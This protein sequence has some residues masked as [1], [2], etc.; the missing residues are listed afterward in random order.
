M[1]SYTVTATLRSRHPGA[2]WADT[3]H[4][5]LGTYGAATAVDAR[6]RAQVIIT[7][8]AASVRQA[9]DLAGA[10]LTEHPVVELHAQLTSDYDNPVRD[11]PPLLSIADAATQL[12]ITRQAVLD[13]I[14]RG[15]L[16]ARKVGRAYVVTL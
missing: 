14:N 9:A 3:I 13:R 15:T 4:D 10:L 8:E 12:G 7:L 2:E 5:Q 6:G 16:S 11:I 1:T